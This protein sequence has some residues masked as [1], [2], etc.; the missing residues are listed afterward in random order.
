MAQGLMQGSYCEDSW[1]LKVLLVSADQ[2]LEDARHFLL[3]VYL[4]VFVK[5]TFNYVHF[6]FD[7]KYLFNEFVLVFFRFKKHFCWRARVA[8][9][10]ADVWLLS[11]GVFFDWQGIRSKKK[12]LCT[13]Q[14]Q[15]Y[16]SSQMCEP[17]TTGGRGLGQEAPTVKWQNGDWSKVKQA[18]RTTTSR[19]FKHISASIIRTPLLILPKGV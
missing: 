16:C 5:F 11:V 4:F 13:V 14:D 8:P 10:P 2:R 6:W 1:R 7:W 17:I 19:N 9:P 12:R 15:S 18:S 3:F